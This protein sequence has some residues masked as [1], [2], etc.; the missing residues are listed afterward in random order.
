MR[1]IPWL[2]MLSLLGCAPVSNSALV[3]SPRVL[4]KEDA[5]PYIAVCKQ[6]PKELRDKFELWKVLK[7]DWLYLQVIAMP[8]G[9]TLVLIFGLGTAGLVV[10]DGESTQIKRVHAWSEY[11]RKKIPC[12]DFV[13]DKAYYR[14]EQRGDKWDLVAEL[15]AM[16]WRRGGAHYLWQFSW[17]C[18]SLRYV[19]N[20][21][22]PELPNP[23]MEPGAATQSEGNA[24]DSE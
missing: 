6:V 23:R 10:F 14:L 15:H 20:D 1:P 22:R 11:L 12:N 4:A 17:S 18:S 7:H 16:P 3:N 19:L 2:C 21:H 13:L 9:E 5:E 8:N 24:S